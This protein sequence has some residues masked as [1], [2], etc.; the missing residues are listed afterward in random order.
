ME[1]EK[2]N[3]STIEAPSVEAAGP[4]LKDGQAHEY[5]LPSAHTVDHGLNCFHL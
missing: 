2:K 1:T 3:S 4:I 5:V